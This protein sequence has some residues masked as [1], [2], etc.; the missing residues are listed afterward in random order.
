MNI[1]L[2]ID[3]VLHY[4]KGGLPASGLREFLEYITKNH[5]VYWLTT[6]CRGG[7]NRAVEHIIQ[8]NN[9]PSD[10]LA[11]LDKITPKSWDLRKTE[12]IDFGEDF[13]WLDDYVFEDDK[14][15]L[16]KNKALHKL[17]PVNLEGNPNQLIDLINEKLI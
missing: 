11:L 7:A 5:N 2:D 17:I 6:H 10:I 13:V 9:P 1:Y 8:Q 14:E 3:G 16:R 4:K 12:A 15:V